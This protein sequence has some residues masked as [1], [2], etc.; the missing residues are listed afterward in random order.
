ML[1]TTISM[2]AIGDRRAM[3]TEKGCCFFFLFSE[4]GI[5]LLNKTCLLIENC[6]FELFLQIEPF[7]CSDSRPLAHASIECN[8]IK[9]HPNGNLIPHQFDIWPLRYRYESERIR[10]SI[11]TA[12]KCEQFFVFCCCFFLIF[13]YFVLFS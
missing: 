6:N 13:S 4:D 2:K 12:Q 9:V 5:S 7:F 11:K 1:I 10:N 8:S 3:R